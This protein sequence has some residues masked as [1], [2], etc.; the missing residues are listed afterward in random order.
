MTDFNAVSAKM[1]KITSLF[2]S[3]VDYLN[4]A[5]MDKVSEIVTYL[6]ENTSLK[7]YFDGY[8]DSYE[9]ERKL[10][11]YKLNLLTKLK[12]YYKGVYLKFVNAIISEFEIDDIKRVLRVL[13]TKDGNKS[14][15]DR[16]VILKANNLISENT[17]IKSFV[18]S[19]INTKYYKV[20]RQYV[21]DADDVVLFYMEMNLD[22]LYYQELVEIT[23]EF[24]KDE[25]E[26]IDEILGVKIDLLNVAWIYRGIK[27]YGLLPEELLNFAIIGGKRF[28]FD[29]LKSMVY[30]DM[31][32]E[33]I[34]YIKNTD[35]AFLFEGD[36]LD[37]YMD[38]RSS[39]YLFYK[40]REV[41]KRDFFY[42]SK[43]LAFASLLDFE[44]KD[45]RGIME[46]TRFN[47]SVSET[48]NYVVRSYK[49]SDYTWL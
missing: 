49:G 6:K 7:E 17:T 29:K 35:Y 15:K 33:F 47:L 40:S 31:Q 3:D 39:R 10:E 30:M 25:K 14:L 41:F 13:K 2:L 18:Q 37:T 27:Y 20:L 46:A 43:F 42:F 24:P 38:R 1:S 34:P 48:L 21:D 5:K 11:I 4:L 22:K 32:R 8:E 44:V 9:A 23:H 45:I 16:L 28:N 36:M 19:L 26:K 12:H